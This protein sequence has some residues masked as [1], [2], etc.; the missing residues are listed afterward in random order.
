MKPGWRVMD[1]KYQY[2][3]LKQIIVGFAALPSQD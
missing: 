3:T 2:I 1:L